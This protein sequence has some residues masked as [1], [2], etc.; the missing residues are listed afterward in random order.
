MRA[1]FAPSNLL[2]LQWFTNLKGG[3]YILWAGPIQNFGFKIHFRILGF[4]LTNCV[5]LFEIDE[6]LPPIHIEALYLVLTHLSSPKL[7]KI[8]F[9][10]NN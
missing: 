7:S 6:R 2:S 9:L 4:N 10:D 3:V 8:E 1:F 5:E